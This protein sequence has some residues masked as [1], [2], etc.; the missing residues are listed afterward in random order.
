VTYPASVALTEREPGAATGSEPAGDSGQV[1]ARRRDDSE[2]VIRPARGWAPL[3]LHEL[4]AHRQ[5]LYLLTWRNIKVRYKQT[6]LGAAWAVIPSVLTMLVFTVIFGH[7]G[8]LSSDGAPYALFSF[9]ALVPWTFFS[10]SISLSSGSIV[11]NERLVT[12]VYFPRLLIPL[13]ATIVGLLDLAIAFVLLVILAFAFGVYPDLSIL[14]IPPLV[15]LACA[16]AL[17]I[18]LI[19][20]ALNVFYRDVKYVI[21]FL[22]QFW[23]FV[24]PVAYASSIIPKHWQPVYGLNPMTGVIDGFRWAML[25]TAFPW[26]TLPVSIASAI[27]LL[28][29]SL[30]YFRRV[31]DTFADVV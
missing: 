13:A 26:S 25:D 10:S 8:K 29:A 20:S 16:A 5:L 9:C 30:Y 23:L 15:V 19:L 18:G 27:V 17:A 3:N 12:K 28:V 24:T 14:A 1:A 22:I 11:E 21:A 31:E 7:L 6:A 4:L 2:I